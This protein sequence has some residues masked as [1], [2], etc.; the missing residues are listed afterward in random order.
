MRVSKIVRSTVAL[1]A[2]LSLLA[3]A[4]SD[5]S[6]PGYLAM[7]GDTRGNE[8]PILSGYR[9]VDV[10]Y[11]PQGHPISGVSRLQAKYLAYMTS[12]SGSVFVTSSPDGIT[13]TQPSQVRVQ[14]GSG[15]ANPLVVSNAG[16]LA[17]AYVPDAVLPHGNHFL[18]TYAPATLNTTQTTSD[19]VYGT[20]INN[21]R[22]ALSADGGV[23][24]QDSALVDD[25][26]SN[27]TMVQAATFKE[28]IL[29]P[30]DL[31]YL[32]RRGGATHCQSTAVTAPAAPWGCD[33]AM[34]YETES[35]GGVKHVAIAGG[36]FFVD[37]GLTMKGHTAP[38]L[39]QGTSWIGGH[40]DHAHA[41]ILNPSGCTNATT[42]SANS[43]CQVELGITGHASIPSANCGT[44]GNNCRVGTARSTSNALTYALDRSV[45]SIGDSMAQLLGNGNPNTTL[46]NLQRV[47]SEPA[48]YYFASNGSGVATHLA[49]GV[50]DPGVGPRATLVKPSTA[51]RAANI[52]GLEFLLNDDFGSNIGID[53]GSLAI[54]IDGTPVSNNA[55]TTISSTIVNSITTPGWRVRIKDSELNLGDGAHVLRIQVADRDG[56]AIDESFD[57]VVDLTAPA[58]QIAYA[59]AGPLSWPYATMEADGTSVEF[60]PGTALKAMRGVVTNPLGQ[61]MTFER[62][63]QGG[64]VYAGFRF[65]NIAPDG[66]SWDWSWAVPV[67]D[68][69]FFGLPGTYTLEVLGIDLAGNIE[70]PSGSNSRSFTIL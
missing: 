18:L 51:I 60:L 61:K 8:G 10:L 62:G 6:T 54:S 46:T 7:A 68:P 17:V 37:I 57:F 38:L 65:D 70:K 34:L 55:S 49:F 1:G 66:S 47:S 20:V 36:I 41:S 32:G 64:N 5:A 30:T 25:D 43:G 14:V 19:P 59:N 15:P 24:R 31:I 2:V 29:G 16:R 48:R 69:L 56:N 44:A 58:T 45:P 27:P 9:F 33:F 13:W 53:F 11:S 26:F 21:I 12:G 39:S 40:V 23:F 50:D 52:D 3:P 4:A 63:P 35:A 28:K 67:N 22:Y 42:T